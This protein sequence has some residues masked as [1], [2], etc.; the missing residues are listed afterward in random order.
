MLDISIQEI[1]TQTFGFAVL[2]LILKKFAWRP[3]LELLEA[4]RAKIATGL[5][6][7]D[8]AKSD[9][10]TLKADYSKKIALIQEEARGKIQ[11]AIQEG[12][13][14]SR[15]IQESARKQ[16]KEILEKSK[17]DIA[18]ETAKARISL[19]NEI[20]NLVAFA[21]ERIVNEKLTEKKD[22]E[23]IAK[24]LKDLEQSEQSLV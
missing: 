3:V 21:T 13:S 12:K 15:E 7:I 1:L 17:D 11:E 16:A 6:E 14:V 5:G 19:R 2:V 23:L 24:Y 18:I 8:K 9:V 4:R 10:E 22:E 20:A